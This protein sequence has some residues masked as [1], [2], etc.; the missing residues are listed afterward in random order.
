MS[1]VTHGRVVEQ[2]TRLR[3]RYVAERLDAVLADAARHEPT[4]LDFLDTVLRQEVDAK[5]RT[6]VT[7]GLKI[8]HF[9]AVKTLDD[10]DFKFQPS[11]DQRLVRELAP[12]RFLSQ[13]ENVLI[14]GARALARRIWPS[15]SGAPSSKPA[16]R[17]SSSAPP[18]SWRR[19]PAPKPTASSRTG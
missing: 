6:R 16:T 4:Y 18:H 3:L 19:S 11:V 13:A 2:L 7:M 8:A 1:A 10:F 15:P 14:F 9:P 17:C 5:Q 12:G